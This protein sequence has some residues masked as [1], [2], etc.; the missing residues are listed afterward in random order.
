MGRT[1]TMANTI[2]EAAG[3]DLFRVKRFK[4]DMVKDYDVI[5][6]GSPSMG[7]EE[8]DPNHVRPL[9]DK[10]KPELAGKK[11]ALFGSCGW[12]HGEWLEKWQAECEEAGIIV[13]APNLCIKLIPDEE[14]LERCRELGRTLAAL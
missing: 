8:V 13:A 12:G 2:A 7:N 14:G 1:E 10:C 11:V 3:A 6:W 9:F 4:A 5:A